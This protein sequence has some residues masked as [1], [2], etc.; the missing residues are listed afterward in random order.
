MT[1]LELCQQLHALGVV[2]R[3]SP[4]GTLRYKA[5]KGVMTPALVKGLRQRRGEVHDL[6]EEWSERA[7]II[8]YAGG[9]SQ[10]EAEHLAWQ[11]LV[12]EQ[13]AHATHQ[14]PKSIKVYHR[15]QSTEWA[16]PQ[17]FFDALNAE[18][19]FTLDVAAQPTNAKCARY[20]TPE[21]D[22]LT[23]PWTGVCWMNP[24]Y[25][26]TIEP[27][28]KKAYE[29]ALQGATVVSLVPAR[30]DTR[31]WHRYTVHGEL[32]YVQG[33]LHFGGAANAAPFPSVVVIFR[34]RE[35]PTEGVQLAARE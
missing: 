25:G 20:F 29:S 6:V 18:F 8:E 22:G 16:T 28:M 5:P 11:C 12:Q 3:P 26:R 4:D 1:T 14:Q 34:P 2:L 35:C 23:Q 21:V 10:A 30:T 27:W 17:D 7:A 24:P 31:W 19:G 9:L 15:S 32:R 13:P 33:R